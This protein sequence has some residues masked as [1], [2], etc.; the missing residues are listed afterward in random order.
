MTDKDKAETRTMPPDT[1]PRPQTG[2]NA[3]ADSRNAEDGVEDPPLPPDYA[4]VGDQHLGHP[5]TLKPV[6]PPLPGEQP[7][8]APDEINPQ[9]TVERTVEKDQVRP[10]TTA[11]PVHD[12]DKVQVSKV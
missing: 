6:P 2:R 11:A 8:E 7:T 3:A 1:A 4:V 12:G 9:Q 10:G 5:V